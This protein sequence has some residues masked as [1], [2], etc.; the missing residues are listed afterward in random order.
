MFGAVKQILELPDWFGVYCAVTGTAGI[1]LAAFLIFA[2]IR[3][4][5]V[6]PGAVS[7]FCQAAVLSMVLGAVHLF[8][9]LAASGLAAVWLMAAGLYTVVV[10]GVML[11][12][13]AAGEKEAYTKRHDEEADRQ[14]S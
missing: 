2:S 13:V 7:L 12:V 14:N 4:L 3:L 8:A 1:L 9:T 6:K 5:Q 10:R 11:I